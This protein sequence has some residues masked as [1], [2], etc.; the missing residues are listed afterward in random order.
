MAVLDFRLGGELGP[1]ATLTDASHESAD[2][3]EL[4]AELARKLTADLA[5]AG[6]AVV[7]ADAVHGTTALTA[8]GA[9]DA[10]LAER[11]A[12]KVQANLVVLAALGRYRQREGT[13]WAAQTPASV[14]YQ[15]A[16]VRATDGAVVTIDRF[17][18]TQQ[19]LSENLFD[20]GKYLEAGGRWLTREE[21]A[22]GALRQTAARLS[23]AVRGEPA[24]SKVPE[25][26]RR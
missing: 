19:A 10:R 4:G 15:A 18:Y 7:E 9:Y 17:S 21:I 25:V 23:A 12:R 16:L 1:D 14:A 11:V 24:G 26:L 20:L 6:V 3:E 22:D 13:A 5:A 8:S 2:D